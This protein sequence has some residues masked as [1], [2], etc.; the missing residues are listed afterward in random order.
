MLVWWYWLTFEL[1]K[2][3]SERSEA[4]IVVASA[5]LPRRARSHRPLP[6]TTAPAQAGL[7]VQPQRPGLLPSPGQP[8][9]QTPRPLAAAVLDCSADCSLTP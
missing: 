9:H 2:K 1:R 7:L 8:W 3:P 5:E 6:C 4:T